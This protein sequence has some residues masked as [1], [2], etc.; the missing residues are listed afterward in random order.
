[1]RLLFFLF[2]V[3]GNYKKV[4]TVFKN[5]SILCVTS[6]LSELVHLRITNLFHNNKEVCG[7]FKLMLC[8][9]HLYMNS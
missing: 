7:C 6:V 4:L 5:G 9:E 3:F 1:M 2:Q 8:R